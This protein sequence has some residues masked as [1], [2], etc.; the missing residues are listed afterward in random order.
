MRLNRDAPH[1]ATTLVLLTLLLS[2]TTTH[3]QPLALESFRQTF[4]PGLTVT[5]QRLATGEL[6]ASVQGF[7]GDRLVIRA[8]FRLRP[9]L[10]V[11][12]WTVAPSRSDPGDLRI[13]A[14]GSDPNFDG[15]ALARQHTAPSVALAAA[16]LWE[17]HVAERAG[18]LAQYGEGCSSCTPGGNGCSGWMERCNGASVTAACNRH[19]A[20]YRCGQACDSTGRAQCDAQFRAEVRNAT[21][22]TWCALIYWLG[23]RGLGWLFYQQPAER[24]DMQPDTYALGLALS[25]CPTSYYHLCTVYVL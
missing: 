22:S 9:A 17:D 21:G 15:A 11:G 7:E 2:A 20:C 13:Y 4:Y 14:Y 18:L 6:V 19:D 5:S 8:T 12:E 16:L 24:F 23:V 10:G 3:A 1:P 25:G